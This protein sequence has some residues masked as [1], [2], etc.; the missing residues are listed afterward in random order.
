MT[1]PDPARQAAY[2][3]A[4]QA[5]RGAYGMTVAALVDAVWPVAFQAG[6]EEGR[7][8]SRALDPEVAEVVA[9]TDRGL[10]G[11]DR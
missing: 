4:R 9:D 1:T 7:R 6:L 2:E 5:F 3:A 10:R 11:R 8:Q